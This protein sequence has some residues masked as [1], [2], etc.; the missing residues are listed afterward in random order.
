MR[1][2]YAL[3]TPSEPAKSPTESEFK[4]NKNQIRWNFQNTHRSNDTESKENDFNV[5]LVKNNW[6]EF[7]ADVPIVYKVSRVAVRVQA[8][9]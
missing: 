9:Q 6:I 5:D 3:R 1:P 2:L 8:K 4:T 7:A